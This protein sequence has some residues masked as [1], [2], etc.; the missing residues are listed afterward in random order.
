MSQSDNSTPPSATVLTELAPRIGFG[1]RVRKS[2]FFEATLRWGCKA[3]S[4]YNHMYMPLYYESPVADYWKLIETVTLWDVAVERQ[5]EITGP[6]AARFLQ[7]MTPRNLSTMAVGQCKYVVICDQHGGVINDPVLLKLGAN[8]FW[9]SMADSDLLLWA[10]GLQANSGFNV[11]LSEPDVSPLQVQGPASVQAMTDLFGDWIGDLKYY[12]FAETV[13]DGMPLVV[14]RTGWS[15]ERG[16]EIFLRDSVYGDKLWELIMAA[17]QRHG[18][19]PGAPS[20]IRRIEGGLL[21]YGADMDLSVNP[22]E[23]GLARL[24]DLDMPADFVGKGA[25]RRIAAEGP[26]RKLVG[27]ELAGEPLS[28]PNEEPWSL[29]D[30]EGG[31]AGKLTSAVYSPRLDRNIA[32]ALVRR[33]L[34]TD[35]RQLEVA[36]PRAPMMGTVVPFPFHDPQKQIPAT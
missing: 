26:L 36:R 17:G 10:K 7:Y 25:L 3:Y 32:L 20:T 14:S 6:D 19:A 12:R 31:M 29:L 22:Y 9:L 24:I 23:L 33:D 4:I 13:F 1:S 27:M 16:Y 21:S 11:A 30:G 18:I 34:A 8:Q 28:G 2:P 15:S 5:L 35:G